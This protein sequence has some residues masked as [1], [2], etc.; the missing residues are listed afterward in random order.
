MLEYGEGNTL[1]CLGFFAPVYLIVVS[2]TPEYK[3]NKMQRKIHTI[4]ASICAVVAFLWMVLV[5]H[6]YSGLIVSAISVAVIAYATKT[7][8]SCKI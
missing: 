4:G 2:L 5:V 8:V 7:A 6:C 3:T 1:Q